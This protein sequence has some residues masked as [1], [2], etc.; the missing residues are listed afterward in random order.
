MTGL[1][2]ILALRVILQDKDGREIKKLFHRVIV[3]GAAPGDVRIVDLPVQGRR[4]SE[5]QVRAVGKPSESGTKEV[6]FFW[7][8][9]VEGKLPPSAETVPA[10]P[11]DSTATAWTA[12]LK[13]PED[14]KGPTSLSVQFLNTAGAAAFDSRTIEILDT[15][16]SLVGRLR[17]K[18]LEGDRPQSG[19]DVLVQDAKGAVKQQGKTGPDGVFL[20]GPLEQGKYLVR[21]AKPATPS[22]GQSNAAVEPGRTKLVTV[23]LF[24]KRLR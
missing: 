7:G 4:G 15:E 6:R 22:V 20:T 3:D 2:G 19:L 11:V 16:P 18:V 9:P 12:K 10:G 23:D 14:K 1:S 24:Y 17:V 8:K 5:I 21:S 13:L